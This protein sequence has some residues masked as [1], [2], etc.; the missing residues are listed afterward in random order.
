MVEAPLRV[1]HVQRVEP[2]VDRAGRASARIKP[3][4][5]V[6]AN[7][8]FSCASDADAVRRPVP[9]MHG[10][11]LLTAGVRIPM[12][13]GGEGTLPGSELLAASSLFPECGA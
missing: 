6:S 2:L 11:R 5:G 3:T 7:R 4:A 13:T 1:E 8:I 12:F 10:S 9:L